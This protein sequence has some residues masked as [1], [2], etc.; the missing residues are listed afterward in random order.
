M[1]RWDARL[2]DVQWPNAS[3][4]VAYVAHNETKNDYKN[5]SMICG[6]AKTC[7]LIDNVGA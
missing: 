1:G 6:P 2:N 7:L 5:A 3:P 4:S